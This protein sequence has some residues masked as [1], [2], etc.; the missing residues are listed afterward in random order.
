MTKRTQPSAERPEDPIRLRDANTADLALHPSLAAALHDDGGF[1]ML[2][3]RDEHGGVTTV[4]LAVVDLHGSEPHPGI[5]R[6]HLLTEMVADAADLIA[7]IH[8]RLDRQGHR[9]SVIAWDTMDAEGQRRL[10]DLG[11]RNAGVWPYF[12]ASHPGGHPGAPVEHVMGYRDPV[13]SVV[14]LVRQATAPAA[15]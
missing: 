2:A 11:Y 9:R 10:A 15:G 7:S 6:I 14:D 8:D 13:G 5:P 1:A 3:E 4:A 12:P